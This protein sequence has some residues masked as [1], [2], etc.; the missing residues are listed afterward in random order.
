MAKPWL[1]AALT[2]TAPA[3]VIEPLAPA[4]AVIVNVLIAK[5]AAIVWLASTF[6]K[7]YVVTAPTLTPSTSTS[8]TW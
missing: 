1:A 3:G 6:V 8:S 7:L 4:L 2:T 5:L